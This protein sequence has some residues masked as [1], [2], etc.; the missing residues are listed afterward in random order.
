MSACQG[1]LRTV[2][3]S[4]ARMCMQH[5]CWYLAQTCITDSLCLRGCYCVLLL[6]G[7][8]MYLKLQAVRTEEGKCAVALRA[9]LADGAVAADFR[10]CAQKA[11][12]GGAYSHK[13][14][15]SLGLLSSSG[16]GWDNFFV[17]GPITSIDQLPD[18]IIDG[19]LKLR[20]TLIKL[21]GRQLQTTAAGET[22]HARISPTH[23]SLVA[24]GA[25][26]L[27]SAV[28]G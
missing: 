17:K 28:L 10:L 21:D 24:S 8:D 2:Q 26:L 13:K 12:S 3:Q 9:K 14:H 16:R 15:S 11:G 1:M 7:F 6:Q 25:S 27:T 20:C 4:H 5:A 22:M 23:L 19:K 18:F